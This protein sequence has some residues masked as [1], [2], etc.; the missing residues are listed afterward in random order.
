ML[1]RT[2]LPIQMSLKIFRKLLNNR[3]SRHCGRIPQSTKRPSQHV[4]RKFPNQRNVAL[5][6]RT[7][8]ALGD[9]AAMPTISIVE[10]F[11]EDF[12]AHL[13]GH[14]CPYEH[15]NEAVLV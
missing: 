8:C 2:R 5:L 15:A 7:F 4:L 14:P 12:E 3:D 10:K 13:N 6:G 9:A 1:I 11:P